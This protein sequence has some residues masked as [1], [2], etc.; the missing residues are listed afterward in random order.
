MTP[1]TI[2]PL[3][4]PR[5]I[6]AR[7]TCPVMIAITIASKARYFSTGL[8]VKETEWQNNQVQGHPNAR[9]YNRAIRDKID[10]LERDLLDRQLSG[11]TVSAR[12]VKAN[13]LDDLFLFAEDL[14]K[15]RP[16][17]TVRR[18]G[19]EI[20]R[21]KAYAGEKL[22]LK[23]VTASFL[24]DYE[25][26]ERA[27]GMAQNTLNTTARWIKSVLNKARREGLLKEL[28][29]YQTPRYIQS[30]R[31]YLT[32][33]ELALWLKYWRD[34]GVSG[35]LYNTLTWFLFGCYTGLR[36]SDWGQFDY[37]ARVRGDLLNL[38]AKKNGRWVVLPIGPT[39]AEIISVVRD[40][41]K[42]LS[43]DKSRVHLKILAGRIGTLKNITCHS[44]RH[45]F[46]S[47]CAS[48]KLPKSVTA[49][50]MG[51]TDKVCSVYYHLAGNDALEQAGALFKV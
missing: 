33:G 34:K 39:L 32:E 10:A 20:G 23:E 45:G 46:G 40:L 26:H 7:G 49:D 21:L 47:L 16:P 2:R 17:A 15:T 38:R 9:L 3:I 51:I 25:R 28:P 42:P 36:H 18:Y 44:A 27:R 30:E 41:P 24:R 6:N 37:D 31:V 13:R 4:W 12:K 35:N 14:K 29:N 11:E 5:K 48:L 19:T 43:G 50:L 1:Y 22:H 8:R